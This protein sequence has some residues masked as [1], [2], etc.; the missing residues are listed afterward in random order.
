MNT[1]KVCHI[2]TVHSPF[3]VRILHKECKSLLK[4][5]YDVVLIAQHE[6]DETIEGI[7]IKALLKVKSR[8]KRMVKLPLI[9]LKKALEEK[10]DVYHFHD[11]ELIPVGLILK[12][13]GKKVIYDIHEDV[14][15]QILSK[16]YLDKFGAKIIAKIISY[17][18]Q[19]IENF[20]ARQFDMLITATPY[21]RDRFLKINLNTIDINNYPL[22][23]ELY[24]PTDWEKRENHIAYIGGIARIRG[25]ME[26]VKALEYV[27][28]TLHLA[29]D[30]ESKEL[31]EYVKSLPGWKKVKYYGYLGRKDIKEILGRVKIGLVNFLPQ[32]NH[33]NAMPNK[34]FEYMS[35]SIPVV[36]SDFP[37]WKEIIEENNC[38][39]CVDPLN[40]QEIAEAIEYLINHP[41]EAKKMGENGRRAV[42]EKYN[43]E[44]ESKKLIKVY[45]TLLFWNKS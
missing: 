40:P 41:E 19:R 39:I 11:P 8:L 4:T 24:I 5:G 30:F 26:L 34:L 3:D 37:L 21:I 38:G 28:T 15:R 1:Y 22:L 6:R 42:E 10:A 13:C 33:I 7:K 18:F 16:P 2:T 32:P 12:L 43:W 14:P 44:N 23:E 29:G 31:E 25:I 27:D 35:A 20:A 36:A 45:E 17:L 9:T